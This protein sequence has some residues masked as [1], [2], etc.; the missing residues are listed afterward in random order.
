[1]KNYK[2]IG[3]FLLSLGIISCDVNNDLKS[4]EE[5]TVAKVAINANGLDF[6]KYV[7]VG[8]SF[9]AGFTD[10]ALFKAGQENSFP[11]ILSKKFAMAGGGEFTQPLMNDNVGG[12]LI[13]N[14]P[15]PR[16]NPRLYFNGSTPA[17]LKAKS[18]TEAT[19]KVTTT[20]NFGVPGVKSFHLLA[21]GYGSL[22][23][24]AQGK[25]NPYF[26]RFSS[27][28]TATVIG[29]VMAQS[30]T[31]FTLS[32]IGGNDVL[33]YALSGGT[34][35]N[36]SPTDTNPT[37][38]LNPKT[39]K[40]NDI[41]NPLVF[42]NVFSSIVNTLTA[43]GAK[44]VVATVPYITSLAHFTTVP[45]NP[46]NPATNATFAAQIPTLNGVFGVLNK[47]YTALGKTERVIQFSK[48]KASPVVIKDE[49]LTDLSVQIT[50]ALIASGPAFE[51]FV[52]QFGL[53]VQ[54]APKVAGLLGKFYG[55]SRQA[56]SKDLFV[57]PS[58]RVIGKVDVKAVTYLV[59]QGLPKSLAGQF[60][61]EGIT[62]P[63]E[64]KWVLTPQ[65]QKE[66]KTATDAYNKTITSVAEAKGLAL[67][68]FKGILEKASTT[69]ITFDNYNMNTKLVTGGLISLD[70]VHLTAR[71]Y[72]LMANE[73][74]KAIDKKYGS[75]FAKATNGLAKAG[76]YPT[77][78][79]PMLK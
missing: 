58:S 72:A 66:I 36:Q 40:M 3:L 13:G 22:A 50:K 45:H 76:N 4:I 59:K 32:E 55:Q 16:F 19:K 70:G 44:G 9:T 39:Y 67:V 79:S 47:V 17:L 60:S 14:K 12:L 15:N 34:G 77:N 10:G 18:T 65:E 56:T 69:G 8:A 64:D 26:V 62:K 6:S 57:L 23:G 37:G 61:I 52:K 20:G 33:G 41:T 35:V 30:P 11:N 21:P 68:D 28:P 51:A 48:D 71:G 42:G 1:M 75:N 74:L 54:A 53:P 25:A 29:D 7:S 46:L 38:N 73:V 63:L 31:F 24:L 5:P 78:Y 43:K 2:Y 49:N 27:T